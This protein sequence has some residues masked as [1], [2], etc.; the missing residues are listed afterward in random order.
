[1]THEKYE[2]TKRMAMIQEKIEQIQ[3][4]NTKLDS[5]FET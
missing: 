2:A 4:E 5:E 3:A 1:M